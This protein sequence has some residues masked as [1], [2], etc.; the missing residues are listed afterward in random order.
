VYIFT[1]SF[2]PSGD[3]HP[4]AAG[5]RKA[6]EEFIPLLNIYY[7][8]WAATAP[9]SPQ[10]T[11]G[12]EQPTAIPSATSGT[13]VL[14]AADG[15]ITDFDNLTP[16]I[17]AFWDEATSTRLTCVPAS[18]AALSGA[19]A[20]KMDFEVVAGSWAT[21]VLSFDPPWIGVKAGGWFIPCMLHGQAFPI[22]SSFTQ[23][24]PTIGKHISVIARPLRRKLI[25][26]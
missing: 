18:D 17:A 26:G 15:L 12:N 14:P 19:S 4:S 23:D 22:T 5:N 7:N 24:Q 9:D 20:L 11:P 16:S 2:Y 1:F 21:C 13:S 8:R 10:P 6:T 25:N 3:D